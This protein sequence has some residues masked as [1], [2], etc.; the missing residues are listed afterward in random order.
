MMY[1]VSASYVNLNYQVP[2]VVSHILEADIPENASI[3]QQDVYSAELSDGR[4]DDSIP[5]FDA[6][7]IGNGISTRSPYL[8]D[9]S[10]RCLH[11][12]S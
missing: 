9:H 11:Q 3:V 6:V 5:V 1:L 4:V 2:V 10:V 7:V 12:E 8:V